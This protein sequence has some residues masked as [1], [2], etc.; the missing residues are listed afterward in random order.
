M[1]AGLVTL[2]VLSLGGGTTPLI[3]STSPSSLFSN[4]NSVHATSMQKNDFQVSNNKNLDFGGSNVEKL[5]TKELDKLPD[6]SASKIEV[7]EKPDFQETQLKVEK[8][9]FRF[10]I[11]DIFEA[12]E[13]ERKASEFNSRRESISSESKAK[14]TSSSHFKEVLNSLGD[15]GINVSD[16]LSFSPVKTVS[17]EATYYLKEDG[18]KALKTFF[19]EQ[20]DLRK[21]RE[22]LSKE[23]EEGSLGSRTRRS[24]EKTF[25]SPE[26][27]KKVVEA[28]DKIGWTTKGL[29]WAPLYNLYSKKSL[30][31]SDNPFR[32]L[33]EGEKDWN[34]WIS[35]VQQERDKEKKYMES[36]RL[37]GIF[38][39]GFAVNSTCYPKHEEFRKDVKRAEAEMEVFVGRNLLK[40]M[41]RL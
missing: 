16:D 5:E 9:N 38:L 34:N 24:S 37:C 20:I 4:Q 30:N 41:K 33:L 2:T 21:K 18:R 35:K 12:M 40:K 1:K 17:E 19:E 8:E 31:D 29:D 32:F 28:L 36:N 13:K 39:L 27:M 23:F 14:L 10:S 25:S 22:Q 26:E 3:L 7:V 6:S 11:T 15:N